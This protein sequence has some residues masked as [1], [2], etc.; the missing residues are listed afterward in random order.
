MHSERSTHINGH[1][2]R[3]RNLLSIC[4]R[5]SQ[6]KGL[7]DASERSAKGKKCKSINNP[8]RHVFLYLP[9]CSCIKPRKMFSQVYHLPF[10]PVPACVMKIHMN[11]SETHHGSRDHNPSFRTYRIFVMARMPWMNFPSAIRNHSR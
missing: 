3:I 8:S 11:D 7:C 6:R 9:T 1:S 10:S 4:D 2:L 5:P